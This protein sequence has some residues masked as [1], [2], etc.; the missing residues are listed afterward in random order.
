MDLPSYRA[1]MALDQTSPGTV[2][3]PLPASVNYTTS[4]SGAGLKAKFEI[5]ASTFVQGTGLTQDLT[6][7][8]KNGADAGPGVVSS[9]FQEIATV[10]DVTRAKNVK[11]DFKPSTP[12]A[13]VLSS[14]GK[15]N[16]GVSLSG[17]GGSIT[18]E[19]NLNLVGIGVDLSAYSNPKEGVSL[20]TKKN[21]LMSTYDKGG[22]T[23][24][25]VAL[26]GVVYCWGD[27]QASLGHGSVI[28][29]KWGKFDLTGAMTAYGKDPADLVSVPTQG[30][31]DITAK[32]INLKFDPTYISGILSGLPADFSLQRVRWLQN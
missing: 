8:P 11:V 25:K 26:K 19:D 5:Q 24:K 6:I 29:S 3:P 2:N 12:S 20:Y 18:A 22:A 1:L 14:T 16:L 23:Y 4:G 7:I 31:L 9:D 10:T 32:E 17:D 13:A 15:V 30:K 28:E 27:F 21:L